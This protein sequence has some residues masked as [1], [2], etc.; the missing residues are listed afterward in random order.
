MKTSIASLIFCFSFLFGTTISHGQQ[1]EKTLVKSFNLKGNQLVL[2]DLAG[3]VEVKEWN[4]E[5]MRIQITVGLENGTEAML[6][7]LVQ[8]GRY[9][10]DSDDTTGEFT[11]LAPGLQRKVT[12]RGNELLENISYTIFAPAKVSI[13]LLDNTSTSKEDV[14]VASQF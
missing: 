7:S 14:K 9:N 12:V 8:A 11:V 6:K 10:L 3:N 4:N 13:K 1:A 5:L 2:L